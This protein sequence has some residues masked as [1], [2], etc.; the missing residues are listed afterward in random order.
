MSPGGRF[1]RIRRGF[2]IAGGEGVDRS[3]PLRRVAADTMDHWSPL[4]TI[5]AAQ[6]VDV[7]QH[8]ERAAMVMMEGVAAADLEAEG[9][10]SL[11][12]DLLERSDASADQ[13][14]QA[15][16][17]TTEAITQIVGLV[18]L[19]DGRDKAMRELSGEVQTLD[20]RVGA[21]VAIA[22]T[23]SILALNAK[24][25][26]SRAGEAG[27]GFA[28]VA[29]EVGLLS[30]A[31]AGAAEDI[32]RGIQ[33][34]TSLMVGHHASTAGADPS[35]AAASQIGDRLRGIAAAQRD[36]AIVLSQTTSA[37]REAAQEV[38]AS[39]DVV[40]ERTTAIVGEAQFQDI[41]RQSLESVTE[42]LGDLSD[43]VTRVASHLR[44]SG[45]LEG[46]RQLDT[47]I[48]ELEASYVSQRQRRIH[49]GTLGGSGAP[50]EI[51]EPAIELF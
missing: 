7:V 24:I 29:D 20:A 37:T 15:G 36:M 26:A 45:D 3:D 8:T 2:G 34:V 40:H 44:E 42:A 5:L 43:R 23:T 6:V 16:H 47:S 22:R 12:Q 31:T 30:Q 25:E 35:S 32:R 1:S 33:Q 4:L 14:D 39:A 46:L 48:A 10:V 9:L 17:S 27:A 41:T 49:A 38:R 19:L 51:G 13:A 11:T 18:D 21:I 28:V 50:V